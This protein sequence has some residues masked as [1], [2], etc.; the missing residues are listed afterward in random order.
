M[1]GTFQTQLLMQVL[2]TGMEL[3]ELYHVDIT[4]ASKAFQFTNTLGIALI[5][6]IFY[7]VLLAHQKSSFMVLFSTAR[8]CHT[9]QSFRLEYHVK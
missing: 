1:H 4:L 8:K 7:Q 5:T 3:V 6:P 2:F 9:V